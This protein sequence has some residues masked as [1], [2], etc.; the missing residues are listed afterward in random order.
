[1][2]Q[3]VSLCDAEVD[4]WGGEFEI[5]SRTAGVGVTV[6]PGLLQMCPIQ[7]LNRLQ[8]VVGPEVENDPAGIGEHRLIAGLLNMNFATQ[9]C[10]AKHIFIRHEQELSLFRVSVD[11]S[12]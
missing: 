12:G 9:R 10:G 3:D 11:V 4:H 5:L 1:M 2:P 8:L 6:A 7:S